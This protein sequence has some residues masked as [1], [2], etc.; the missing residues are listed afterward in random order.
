MGTRQG[1]PEPE[2]KARAEGAPQGLAGVPAGATM[3]GKPAEGRRA[4]WT[5]RKRAAGARAVLEALSQEAHQY[6]KFLKKSGKQSSSRNP[7]FLPFLCYGAPCPPAC[8]VGGQG[9]PSLPLV[10]N[11]EATALDAAR[12]PLNVVDQLVGFDAERA[13][14]LDRGVDA[15][16]AFAALKQAD[17]SPVKARHDGESFL[18]VTGLLADAGKVAAELDRY[19]VAMLRHRRLAGT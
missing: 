18:G 17:L 1:A 2:P 4:A 3:K 5:E 16:D 8:Q 6:H 7:A 14:Q 13:S 15:R 9:A 12:H 19:R 10:S 11:G